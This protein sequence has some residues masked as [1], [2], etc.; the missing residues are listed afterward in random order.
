VA[1][2]AENLQ[3]LCSETGQETTKITIVD[4]EVAYALSIG[5]EI[6]NPG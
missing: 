1:V 2:L 3:Y 5:T 4:Y 6:N